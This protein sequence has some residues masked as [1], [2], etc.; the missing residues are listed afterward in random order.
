MAKTKYKNKALTWKS[1]YKNKSLKSYAQKG[2]KKTAPQ[3]SVMFL[4]RTHVEGKVYWPNDGR[5]KGFHPSTI[6]SLKTSSFAK[7]GKILFG[8]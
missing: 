1:D 2:T 5:V 6:A 3:E 8:K 7:N 4:V